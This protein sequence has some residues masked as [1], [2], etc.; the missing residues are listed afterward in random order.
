MPYPTAA[1]ASQSNKETWAKAHRSIA[2]NA[3]EFVKIG[4]STSNIR[5]SL[6]SKQI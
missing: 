5:T 2:D 3:Q 1:L 4:G 6:I